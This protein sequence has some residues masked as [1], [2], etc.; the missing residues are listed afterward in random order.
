MLSDIRLNSSKQVSATMDIGKRFGFRG[1]NFIHNSTINSRGVGILISNKLKATIHNTYKDLDCNILIIDLTIFGKRFTLGSVYGPNTDVENFFDDILHTCEAFSNQQIIVGGDWNTTVDGRPIN[2]NIDTINMVDIPSRRRTRWLGN[3]C[4]RLGL[5]DPYRHFYPD[6]R[7]FTYIP[8][9]VANQNRSRLDFFLVTNDI[10]LSAKNCMISHHVDN[11]LFDHKSVRLSFRT[12]K[13]SNRQIIKDTILKDKDLPF[14][15]RCQVTEHYIHHALICEDFPIEFKHELLNTIGR[16][17]QNLAIVRNL[18]TDIATGNDPVNINEELANTREEIVRLTELLPHIDY[19]DSLAL[20]CD[21]KAFLETLVM[22]I[23]NATL[24]TQ[25]FFY[26]IKSKTKDTIKKQLTLLKQNYVG[27]QGDIFRLEARLSRIVDSE[28]RDEISMNRNFERL[29]DEKITPYFMSL[30]KQ[31]STDALLS[32]IR[33]DNGVD[34]IDCSERE[35]YLVDYYKDLYKVKVNNNIGDNSI[36]DFLGEVATHP[37][38]LSSKLTDNE[39][40]DLER[41]LSL[42]EL[43]SSAKKGKLNTAPGIDGMTNKSILNY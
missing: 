42:A 16:I 40:T 30:A 23:K 9:A 35:N 31:L 8:N 11:L 32:D 6:R 4:T 14:I 39:R 19:L 22:S 10:L 17:N 36:N 41:P 34:F 15:V 18:L 21:N 3:L 43:D 5:S 7:E 38:V 33:N 26:K 12:N 2:S 24:S 20:T 25:H 1:Y 27:N 29:N 37:D 28:L 13:N